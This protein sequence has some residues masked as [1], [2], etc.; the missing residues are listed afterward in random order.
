MATLTIPNLFVAGT[1]ALASEVNANFS[2][3][4]S[5]SNGGIDY[6]NMATFSGPL[7]FNIGNGNAITIQN[8]GNDES[9]K[10]TQ[11][12]LLGASKASILITD[13][14]TQTAVDSAELKMLLSGSAT[15]PAIH[16]LH[17]FVDTFKLTRTALNIGSAVTTTLGGPL[18]LSNPAVTGPIN[19]SG[20]LS[21]TGKETINRT[22]TNQFLELANT[23]T[24]KSLTVTPETA[25]FDLNI[26]DTTSA[27]QF[28]I[29][30]VTKTVIDNNGLDGSYLKTASVLPSAINGGVAAQNRTYSPYQITN[31]TNTSVA[32]VSTT[33]TLGTTTFTTSANNKVIKI[34]VV[35][36]I[37]DSAYLGLTSR[38]ANNQNTLYAFLEVNGS[39]VALFPW[40]LPSGA[41]PAISFTNPT[42]TS[43]FQPQLHA[44]R[45][46]ATQGIQTIS[47]KAVVGGWMGDTTWTVSGYQFIIYELG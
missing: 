45:F 34:E 14:Q 25:S 37:D 21:V 41:L 31:I 47:L 27:Y 7:G 9:I 42:H 16:V 38:N 32:N 46:C 24:S 35:P 13:N 8:N 40:R 2:A 12:A 29:N 36:R 44:I 6:D 23:T 20:N 30:G 17:N 43:P 10:I 18:V 1:P 3:V 39:M 22:S 19:L 15:I 5:W 28:K 4:Q 11:G 26:N 33:A